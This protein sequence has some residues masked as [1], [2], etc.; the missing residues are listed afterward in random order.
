M[1]KVMWSGAVLA[2]V[3]AAA[4]YAAAE[5]AG[6]FPNSLF[7]QCV[8]SSY[9]A[10]TMYN[11]VYQVTQAAV[12]QTFAVVKKV[13]DHPEVVPTTV[14]VIPA[15]PEPTPAREL[16]GGP[17]PCPAHDGRE[18]VLR[19]APM[20]GKIVIQPDEESAADQPQVAPTGGDAEEAEFVPPPMPY[21]R[22]DGDAP[23]QMPYATDNTPAEEPKAEGVDLFWKL[24]QDAASHCTDGDGHEQS[25]PRPT[26]TPDC[27]EDPQYDQQYPGCP[28]MGPCPRGGCGGHCGPCPAPRHDEPTVEDKGQ[29]PA[30]ADGTDEPSE[31]P[32]SKPD[33]SK[34]GPGAKG[35]GHRDVDTTEYRP[36]DGNPV[37]FSSVPY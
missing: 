16:D 14:G 2:L 4:V 35:P 11:P 8:L 5:Y 1:R 37:D 12:G 20:L 9:R 25:G 23:P 22:D 26:G 32:P 24:F 33:E 27:Q 13:M 36:S 21:A 18:A 28:A 30:D 15:D 34:G 19:P 6:R 17:A 29:P 3:A 7:G 10:G 31:T